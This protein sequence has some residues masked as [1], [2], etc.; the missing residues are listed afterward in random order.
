MTVERLIFQLGTNNWQRG[1]EFAPGSGIL[2]EAHHKAFNAMPNVEGYSVYPSKLQRFSAP[3][4]RVFELDHDIPICESISPVSSH[5]WHGMSDGE[6]TSYRSRLTQFVLDW[7][8]EIEAR[9]GRYFNLAIAHHAFLNPLTM[10]DVIASRVASGRPRMPL[11]CF[12]HGTALKMY[13][14][15]RSGNNPEEYP[16]RFLPMIE[17]ER[18][19]DDGGDVPGVDLFAAISAEQVTAL[20]DIFPSISTDRVVLSPNG[21][22]HD[23]FRIIDTPNNVFAER[24]SVL[25][26][27]QSSTYEGSPYPSRS[28][29]AD[30]DAVVMYCGKFADWKRLD[31]LLHAAAIYE[32]GPKRVATLIVGTGP[33]EDQRKLQ[34]LANDQL[35]LR[36][37][38]FLGPRNQ[39]ELAILFNAADVGCFPSYK[40]PF[41]LVFIE[42]MACGTPVIG[43]NSG[44]PR[45]FVIADVGHLVQES[46]DQ[47]LLSAMLADAIIRAIDE[48]WKET[49]GPAAAQYAA[50]NYS[51]SKQ[52]SG[53]LE[54][55]DRRCASSIE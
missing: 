38:Y 13:A 20:T 22:N 37:A 39:D 26:S 34:A 28:V 31:T 27:F 51:V 19:F 49:K 1:G 30:V 23:I 35:G 10:R 47:R 6:I 40:E 2:H 48:N 45:D 52:V 54:E 42:C 18:I 32:R 7:M 17:D 9:V 5:R 33:L 36:R 41:G 43:A 53:L 44:G 16:L 25:S 14:N 24:Q 29:D 3:D 50:S 21:Y 11:L 55:V 4:V 12:V 8:E 15:E 46:D